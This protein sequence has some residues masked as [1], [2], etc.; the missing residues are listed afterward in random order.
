MT[1]QSKQTASVNIKC[2]D[3]TDGIDPWHSDGLVAIAYT[4]VSAKEHG[5]PSLEGPSVDVPPG[6]LSREAPLRLSR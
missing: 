4:A 3:V 6:R 5:A 2:H 1:I